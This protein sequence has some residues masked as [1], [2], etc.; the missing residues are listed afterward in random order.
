MA[1]NSK[2][3]QYKEEIRSLINMGVSVASACKIINAKLPKEAK[4]S[5][6]A[7][8]HFVKKH[9]FPWQLHIWPR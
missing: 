6:N 9:N 7:F 3:E 1:L 8:F 4:I 5:Y 2:M